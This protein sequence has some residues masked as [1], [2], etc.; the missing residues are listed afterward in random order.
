MSNPFVN[1]KRCQGNYG[2]PVHDYKF[3]TPEQIWH[4]RAEYERQKRKQFYQNS[5]RYGAN[6]DLSPKH[7]GMPWSITDTCDTVK[8][9][10]GQMEELFAKTETSFPLH[11]A[12]N[13]FENPN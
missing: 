10:S 8:F 3:L 6:P 7:V 11:K 5:L 4:K 1:K 2:E 9:S 13:V 12:Y